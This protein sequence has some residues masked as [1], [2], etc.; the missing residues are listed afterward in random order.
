MFQMECVIVAHCTGP[1]ANTEET[2][3]VK[4]LINDVLLLGKNKILLKIM[5]FSKIKII[6]CL[7]PKNLFLQPFIRLILLKYICVCIHLHTLSKENWYVL[8]C[9][10]DTCS[11][12]ESRSL[13][14]KRVAY[15]LS[16]Q[17]FL[18]GVAGGRH[19]NLVDEVGKIKLEQ[20]TKLKLKTI[21]KID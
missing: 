15:C 7:I 21:E 5:S 3:K 10:Q 12:E 11:Q 9:L 16:P 2:W 4:W 17:G 14:G 20:Q 8:V 18:L 1:R 13:F 19:I 6:K